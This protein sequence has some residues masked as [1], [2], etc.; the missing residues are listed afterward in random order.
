MDTM[1]R[2]P[3]IGRAVKA[4]RIDR[5]VTLSELSERSG[6]SKGMLS[7]VENGTVNPTIATAWKIA[8]ALGC[9]LHELFGEENEHNEFEIIRREEAYV[10]EEESGTWKIFVLSPPRMAEILELYWVELKENAVI[11]SNPHIAGAVEFATVITGSVEITSGDISKKAGKGDTARYRA[12]IEHSIRNTEKGD[13]VLY[14]TVDF[15]KRMN[16]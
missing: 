14:L 2:P 1:S 7:Q 15:E 13:T 10:F 8:N 11:G 5:N 9:S 3:E 6:V 4:F 16:S 12:D